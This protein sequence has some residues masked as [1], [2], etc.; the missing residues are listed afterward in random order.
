MDRRQILPTFPNPPNEYDQRYMQDLVRALEDL[1]VQLRTPGE[2][3]QT[4]TTF[5]RVS[6]SPAGLEPGTLWNDFGLAR[7]A[8]FGPELLHPCVYGQVSHTSD[9][10]VP[11]TTAG[12]FVSTGVAGALDTSVAEGIGLGTVDTFAIKNVSGRIVRTAVYGSID[13]QTSSAN[14]VLAI[15]FAL[16]GNS[17]AQTEC[18]ANQSTAGVE[19]KLVTRWIFELEPDDEIALHIANVTDTTDITFRRGRIVAA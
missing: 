4:T 6:E 5:T 8:G 2:G 15:R 7:F 1:L 10:L 16:N 17:V 18:R 19:A 12:A 13:A 14:K 3:R 11:I 9:V